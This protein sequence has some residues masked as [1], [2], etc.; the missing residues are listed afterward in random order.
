MKELLHYSK[1]VLSVNAVC[2]PECL[3][4]CGKGSIKEEKGGAYMIL[5]HRFSG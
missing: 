2:R 4:I 1:P 3:I 5:V